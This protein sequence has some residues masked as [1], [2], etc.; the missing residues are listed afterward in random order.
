MLTYTPFGRI[1]GLSLERLSD[2]KIISTISVGRTVMVRKFFTGVPYKVTRRG[3]SIEATFLCH[4]A[5]GVLLFGGTTCAG[6]YT[7]TVS[8][9]NPHISIEALG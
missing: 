3:K 8:E 6:R 2:V 4:K 1:I 9:S 7:F 5:V